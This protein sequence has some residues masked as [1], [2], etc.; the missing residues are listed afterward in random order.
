MV[1]REH[2]SAWSGGGM[3]V[4]G[5]EGHGSAWKGGGRAVHASDTALLAV[6]KCEQHYTYCSVWY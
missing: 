1:G 3:A 5:R 4:P 6:V 2:G